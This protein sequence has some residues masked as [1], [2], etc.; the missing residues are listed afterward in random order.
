VV[1]TSASGGRARPL[2][3]DAAGE[4]WIHEDQAVAIELEL[5][6]EPSVD[7]EGRESHHRPGR[8]GANVLIA[9]RIR[10]DTKIGHGDPRHEEVG[11]P[12]RRSSS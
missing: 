10:H 12:G 4:L 11:E 6:D 9:L 2:V 7:T 5:A 8:V 3:S 1:V